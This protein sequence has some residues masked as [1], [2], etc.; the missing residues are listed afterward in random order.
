MLNRPIEIRDYAVGLFTVLSLSCFVIKLFV[1]AFSYFVD[2]SNWNPPE[3][4]KKE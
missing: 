3:D 4:T 1:N 2:F